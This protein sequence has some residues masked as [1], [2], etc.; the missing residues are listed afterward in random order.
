MRL[1]VDEDLSPGTRQRNGIHA[2]KPYVRIIPDNTLCINEAVKWRENGSAAQPSTG[3]TSATF[4]AESKLLDMG[5]V[6]I[7]HRN[8]SVKTFAGRSR[9]F[10]I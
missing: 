10:A 2:P 3:A 5:R 8:E 9:G 1:G 4:V 7:W 6:S